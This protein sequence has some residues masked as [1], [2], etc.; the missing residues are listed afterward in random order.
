MS[1]KSKFRMA[2][3]IGF[4]LL[5]GCGVEKGWEP[6]SPLASHAEP[7]ALAAV[8]G[9]G[10]H[11][12]GTL[13]VVDRENPGAERVF[14]SEQSALVRQRI[15]GTGS[16]PDWIVFTITDATTPFTL[17]IET[18]AG[19]PARMGVVR[20]PFA[21]RDF[22]IGAQGDVLDI[23]G[24][25]ALVGIPVNNLPG[26]VT[27]EY[28]AE[29]DD[30]RRLVVI[31]PTDDWAYDDFRLFLGT[32]GTMVERQIFSVTRARDGGTTT[33][34]FDLDGAQAT[35]LFPAAIRMEPATLMIDGT[36]MTLT[37]TS[38][39]T[40]ASAFNFYCR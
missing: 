16:G 31:R 10:K 29:T 17:K 18:P 36:T 27:I 1:I 32:P 40:S 4:A 35:A 37:L 7:I 9:I 30:G 15:A 34:V 20:G 22:E 14:V 39:G 6:C 19:G 2:L 8:L 13:Y 24:M 33:I 11:A 28:L 3:I 25:D 21:D 5:G 23:V 12:D 38:P 26:D